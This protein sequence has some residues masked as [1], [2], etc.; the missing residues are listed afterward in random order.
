MIDDAPL[1]SIV[2]L[3]SLRLPLRFGE[4]RNGSTKDASCVDPGYMICISGASI[5]GVI[6]CCMHSSRGDNVSASSTPGA[7]LSR[8]EMLKEYE[9]FSLR[10]EAVAPLENTLGYG[11]EE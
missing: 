2:S 6:R 1:R 7:Q 10:I 5:A 3:V 11:A 8:E 9:R 4:T